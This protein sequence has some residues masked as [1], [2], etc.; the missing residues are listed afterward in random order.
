LNDPTKSGQPSHVLKA[1]E[2][3]RLAELISEKLLKTLD[4]EKPRDT[5]GKRL[6]AQLKA[7]AEEK[8]P[9]GFVALLTSLRAKELG[10]NGSASVVADPEGEEILARVQTWAGGPKEAGRWYRSQPI[11]AFGDRTAE[12]L[13]KSGQAE[14]LRD[15][16]DSIALGGYA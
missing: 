1:D 3:K 11:A 2:L 12:S 13:V 8:L 5:G 6:S 14:A 4:D 15:Y 10:E 16:L 9:D 7:L